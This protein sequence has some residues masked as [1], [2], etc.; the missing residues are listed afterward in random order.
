MREARLEERV[1]VYT[2]SGR[3]AAL[4][5][6]VL[7]A[8]G[9]L[10]RTCATVEE[11]C[12]SIAEGA[13]TALVAEEALT[14][15]AVTRVIDVLLRQPAWS[16]LPL[17]VFVATRE[18]TTES[19]GPLH[20]VSQLG[21]VTLLERPIRKATLV[22]SLRA[23]LRARRRQ[24]EVRSLL[25][26][27]ESRV[28][29]R[30]QFLAMLGHELRNPL[31][32]ILTTTELMSL[33]D[34]QSFSKERSVIERQT[35]NLCRLV[36]DLL[37]VSRVTTGKITLQRAP[38]ALAELL[39]RAVAALRP[40]AQEGA[41]ELTLAVAD[42]GLVVEG[43]SVRLEQVVNNLVT[44]AL[45][46]TPSGGRVRV[47]LAHESDDAVVR[48]AD[49][50]VGISPEVLPRVF[51]LFV[52]ADGT[53]H[54][55]QGGM[56]IGLTLVRSLVE[57]HGGHVSASSE[58]E[59]RGSEFVVRLPVV[60]A[61]APEPSAPGPVEAAEAAEP[62][63]RRIVVVE[64]NA[65]VREPLEVLLRELGHDVESAEDGARGVE[66][67]VSTKP[68]IALVDIGLPILDGYDVA[69]RVRERLGSS[70]LLVALTGYGQ[71]EDRKRALKAGFDAHLTKPVQ[72]A[73]LEKVLTLRSAAIA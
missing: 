14:G 19:H 60:A 34:A 49:D 39:E 68:E 72:I 31:G 25:V 8:A 27:L 55:S 64:D 20:S 51:D 17:L 7:A 40:A 28:R 30:D 69:R 63:R 5:S 23:A 18:G 42:P 16:D 21:N 61:A 11:L 36:D 4:A 53:L 24:Y 2:P 59:G 67:I 73:A 37:E 57:L 41:L 33:R 29:E 65:D 43:D 58:G 26:Q 66:Q 47:S 35:R 52:Q 71:P 3:D 50:G 45:K 1:L 10:C 12:A 56:G 62:A 38:I 44:N 46:Y 54:R 13:G 22:S 70:V 32:A 9:L 6:G 15:S 48:V